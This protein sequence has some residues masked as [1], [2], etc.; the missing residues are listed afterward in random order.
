MIFRDVWLKNDAKARRDAIAAWQAAGDMLGD[1][2]HEARAQMLCIVGYDGARLCATLTC[3][4]RY[5]PHV[6]ENMAFIQIFV[7]PDYRQRGVV[8]PLTV[9]SHA[10]MNR[11]ALEHPQ[12]RIGGTAGRVVV[13]GTLDKPVGGAM[14]ILVGYNL[15]NEPLMIRWFDHF[16]I[17][18]DAARARDPRSAKQNG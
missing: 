3:E 11:Y 10:A 14:M 15:R 2:S 4:V 13:R 9:A 12:L 17:D 18:E 5:M 16:K 8:I 1:L 6:R 7:V